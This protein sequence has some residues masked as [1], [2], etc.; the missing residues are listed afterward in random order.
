MLS[1]SAAAMDTTFGSD[2]VQPRVPSLRAYRV[3]WAP[4]LPDS[5]KDSYTKFPAITGGESKPSICDH[6]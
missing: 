1:A 3:A 5:Y 2:E 6:D 4:P